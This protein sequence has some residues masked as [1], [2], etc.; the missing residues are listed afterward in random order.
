MSEPAPVD[1]RRCAADII[2]RVLN[3]RCPLDEVLATHHALAQ[4]NADDL[5]LTRALAS[6]VLR[7]LGAIDALIRGALSAG[8]PDHRPRTVTA[9]RLG[10]LQ[11]KFMRVAD[12]AAVDTS[13][14]LV[15]PAQRGLVNAVLRRISCDS[16]SLDALDQERVSLPEWLWDA[17]AGAYGDATCRAIARAHLAEPP[18]DLT[19]KNG[20]TAFWAVQLRGLALATGTVRVIAAGA[21]TDLPGYDDGAWWVQ[22]EAAALPAKLLP[23]PAGGRALDL[24]AAP[25]GKTA[26]L[27]A[28]GLRVT[29]Y[30]QSDVRLTRLHANLKRLG[31]EAESRQGDAGEIRPSAPPDA[32]LL[33]APCSSTGTIRRHPDVAWLKQPADIAALIETQD[34][35]LTHAATILPPGAVLLYCTCSLLPAEG[36]DRI[37]ALLAQQP[38][39]A[40]DP[41]KPTELADL[42]AALRAD[43]TVRLLPHHRAEQGGI[44]GFYIARLRRRTGR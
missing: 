15:P 2:D 27:A 6:G 11:L 43:G 5:R 19:I 14:A 8:W 24:C 25:G 34:R 17:V 38:G 36:E 31:V 28:R 30:D 41:I 9:L 26:Q 18:L 29:A 22:D 4:L 12:H 10:V 39:L 40:I 42:T 3:K 23:A 44:D 33:D 37:T 1:P 7:H 35:L 16:A 13:V 20:D 21:V 32:I